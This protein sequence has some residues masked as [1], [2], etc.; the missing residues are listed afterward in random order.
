MGR[1]GG[2]GFDILAARE[3]HMGTEVMEKDGI[4]KKKRTPP[5]TRGAKLERCRSTYLEQERER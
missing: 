3:E 4:K 2:N 1:D 5:L